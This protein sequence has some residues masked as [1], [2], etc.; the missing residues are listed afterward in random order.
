M[1]VFYTV[2][3]PT[4]RERV[5]SFC[6]FAC[7]VGTHDLIFVSFNFVKEHVTPK[8]SSHFDKILNTCRLVQPFAHWNSSGKLRTATVWQL[9]EL[10]SPFA[11]LCITSFQ[12]RGYCVNQLLSLYMLLPRLFYMGEPSCSTEKVF[13]VD[14]LYYF[15]TILLQF[16]SVWLGGSCSSI[17]NLLQILHQWRSSTEN[18]DVCGWVSGF[19]TLYYP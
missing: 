17:G 14:W 9:P 1:P 3:S 19:S 11:S 6:Q 16:A 8:N 4:V 7:R 18:W 2:K 13:A 5:L 10:V 12:W 15:R